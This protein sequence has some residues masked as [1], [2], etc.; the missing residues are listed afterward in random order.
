M[1]NENTLPP[2]RLFFAYSREDIQFLKE[3][4]TFLQ[5]LERHKDVELWYD[6]EILAGD[7]WEQSIKNALYSADIIM[8]LLSA[9]ALASDYFWD[10]EK[11]DALARHERGECVVVPVV[12]R[13]CGWNITELA[14]LQALPKNGKPV[15]AWTSRDEAY[16]SILDGIVNLIKKIKDKQLFLSYCRQANEALGQEKWAEA[17]NYYTEA[18]QLHQDAYTP[19]LKAIEGKIKDCNDE[20]TTAD[21]LK[22]A[23]EYEQGEKYDEAID[24]L[25]KAARLKPTLSKTLDLRI[26]QLQNSAETKAKPPVYIETILG[27]NLMMMRVEGGAFTMGNNAG[28]DDEKPAHHVTVKD[29]YIG[30]YPVT[31]A[32]WQA[33]MGTSALLSNPSY[34]KNRLDCPV[35]NVSWEDIQ[36]FLH[37]LNAHLSLEER[38]HYRLPTEAE[39]EYAAKGGKQSNGYEYAGSDF[40]KNVAWYDSNSR[41]KTHPIGQKTPNEL[42][43]YDMTG[44][45]WEWCQDHWHDNYNDA[46]QDGSAWE[47]EESTVRILRGGSWYNDQSYC[48]VTYR[49]SDNPDN[50]SYFSGF[51]LAI[52]AP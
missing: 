10:N 12:L 45:V 34:F 51:R 2:I 14:K 30:A 36:V 15:V 13:H 8:L 29:F 50:R 23:D 20:I 32:Q 22:R 52:S 1:P 41:N 38:Q 7:T 9:D 21:H 27:L 6:G 25:K 47:S 33:V 4:R 35:E 26:N 46:P 24:Q 49:N 28:N 17:L 16:E 44:N 43:L 42:G 40:I 31:Q 5:P 3:I 39:W 11:A 37:K 18:L 48:R 19:S